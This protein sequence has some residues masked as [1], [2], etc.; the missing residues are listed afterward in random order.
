MNRLLIATSFGFALAAGQAL[1]ADMP[2][3]APYA[4]PPPVASWTGCYFDGGVGY[5][6]WNQD[7]HTETDPG[8]V[9]LSTDDTMGGRGWLGRLGGGC[10]YQAGG[11]FV[12]GV[13]ADYDFMS[14]KGTN[15]ATIPAANS[16][17]AANVTW[18]GS[19]KETGAWYVGGR[20]GYLVTPA[21][22]TYFDGGYT[23]TRFDQVNFASELTGAAVAFALGRATYHGW[24]L[25]GGTEYALDGIVPFHGLFWRTEY[26]FAQYDRK[27]V[28]IFNTTT[29]AS[30]GVAE[31]S[32]KY[33][34]TITSG[35]VWRF[36][37]G[38]PI[39]TRY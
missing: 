9:P 19:E 7:R 14:L 17:T 6:L 22:L 21:L 16:P 35:V 38:G 18:S 37:F 33:V 5:G 15:T 30:I 26:R 20:I 27:D 34:Q 1:A 12:V 11:K 25:G 31:D 2:L 3:K 13:L 36:N 8:R 32:K 39:A 4:P 24:W 10:D 23:E 29:G 28:S